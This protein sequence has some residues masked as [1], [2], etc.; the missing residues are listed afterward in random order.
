MLL[1]GLIF[2]AYQLVWGW[3]S[4]EQQ[5]NLSVVLKEAENQ[6]DK[7]SVEELPSV[8]AE[9][10]VRDFFVIAEKDLFNEERRLIEPDEDADKVVEAPK[11]PKRPEMQG[12]SEVGGQR[13]AILTLFDTAKSTGEAKTVAVND[14]VQGWVVGEISDTTVTLVW[15]DQKEII[16]M[17]DSS[18][19]PAPKAPA[20]RKVAAVNVVRIGAKQ[21]AVQ[22]TTP[23]GME[24]VAAASEGGTSAAKPLN[25]AAIAR[26]TTSGRSTQPARGSRL[27]SRQGSSGPPG[28][29]AA[30]S[31]ARNQQ[32][33]PPPE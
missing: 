26:P 9:P 21:A 22:T 1:I 4:F 10:E 23:E 5:N 6:A 28:L 24:E 7:A 33:V 2:A 32:L 15:N 20:A 27:S 25:P 16:D 17:F 29:I 19:S 31:A 11:F 8:E 12:T 13:R 14:P 18:S 3:R 30:P